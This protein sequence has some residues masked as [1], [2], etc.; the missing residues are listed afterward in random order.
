M[1]LMDASSRMTE[2]VKLRDV[3]ALSPVTVLET[4]RF[5]TFAEGPGPGSTVFLLLVNTLRVVP[6]MMVPV[7]PVEVVV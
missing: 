3:S 6:S 4:V 2:K 1:P 7:S 5:P